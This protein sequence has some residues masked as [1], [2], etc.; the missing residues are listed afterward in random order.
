MT[1]QPYAQTISQQPE[2]VEAPAPDSIK[3]AADAAEGHPL[4][5][6]DPAH[7]LTGGQIQGA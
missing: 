4:N 6:Y 3:A 7:T 5:T 2:P 1:E